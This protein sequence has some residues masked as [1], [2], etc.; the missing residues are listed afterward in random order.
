M[1]IEIVGVKFFERDGAMLV[2][3]QNGTAAKAAEPADDGI[4]IGNAAT[5]EKKLRLRRRE[6]EGE[7]V[8]EAAIG[9]ADHLVFINNEERGAVALDEAVLL[10]FEGGDEDGGAEIFGEIAGGDA[11]IPAA[12]APFGELV[13]GEGARWD[14][15]DGLTTIFTGFGPK[16]EDERLARAGGSLHDDVLAGAQRGDGLLLPEVGNG[17]LVQGGKVGELSGRR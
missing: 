1:E 14:G 13:I 17:D 7:F 12:R 9:V 8:I 10:G 15:V 6:R 2:A 16:F 11:D 4:G 5:E 3:D